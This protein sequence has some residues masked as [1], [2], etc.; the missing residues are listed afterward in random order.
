MLYKCDENDIP[1]AIGKINDD[2]IIEFVEENIRKTEENGKVISLNVIYKRFR[3]WTRVKYSF[4]SS[5]EYNRL[6]IKQ[7]LTKKYEMKGEKRFIGI[8]LME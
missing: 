1:E 8:E 3:E 4:I 5:K 6:D 7:Y 2:I